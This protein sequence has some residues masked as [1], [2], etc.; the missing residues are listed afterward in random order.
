MQAK[1]NK[2]Q[3]SHLSETT[4][5]TRQRK[6]SAVHTQNN[7]LFFDCQLGN[8]FRKETARANLNM[9]TK[10]NEIPFER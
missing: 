9:Y 6:S 10:Q 2:H 7:D 1:R 4:V 8:Q 3:A 5:R